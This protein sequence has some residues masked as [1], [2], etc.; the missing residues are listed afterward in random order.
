MKNTITFFNTFLSQRDSKVSCDESNMVQKRRAT[1]L[2]CR[3]CRYSLQYRIRVDAMLEIH[4][5]CICAR[6]HTKNRVLKKALYIFSNLFS[7]VQADRK[8]CGNIFNGSGSSK[9]DFIQHIRIHFRY[10]CMLI[11][12]RKN[13]KNHQKI[14]GKQ[15]N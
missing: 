10:F 15:K 7:T 9:S 11:F 3:M 13:I 6:V 14:K 5:A 2:Y 8:T 1:F 12:T 4:H